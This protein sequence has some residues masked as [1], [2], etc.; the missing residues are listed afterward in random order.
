[1]TPVPGCAGHNEGANY[2]INPDSV[3]DGVPALTG[4]SQFSWK[5]GQLKLCEGY[6]KVTRNCQDGLVCYERDGFSNVPGCS[7]QGEPN[8][9]YCTNPQLSTK[10][11]NII[12][13]EGSFLRI[14]NEG[15]ITVYRA[16]G[17][18]V[19]WRSAN[20]DDVEVPLN[21]DS[22]VTNSLDSD[23][24][25]SLAKMMRY[26]GPYR[27]PDILHQFTDIDQGGLHVYETLSGSSVEI[28]STTSIAYS[29]V[30][31]HAV[32]NLSTLSFDVTVGSGIKALAICMDDGLD[33]DTRRVSTNCLILGGSK[34]NILGPNKNFVFLKEIVADDVVEAGESPN[35]DKVTAGESQDGP[36]ER[37]IRALQDD[38][39]ANYP[40]QTS[41]VPVNIKLNTIFPSTGPA[42]YFTFM[43]VA[44][45]QAAETSYSLIEN[46]Q[47][48]EDDTEFLRRKLSE[49][50]SMECNPGNLAVTG[51]PGLQNTKKSQ[52]LDFCVPSAK[53]LFE[54]SRNVGDTCVI[55]ADCRSGQCIVDKCASRVCNIDSKH[56]HI[57]FCYLTLF[58]APPL[59]TYQFF[60]MMKMGTSSNKNYIMKEIMEELMLIL[61]EEVQL[62]TKM[63]N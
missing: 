46:I 54:I 27:R 15:N 17:K 45:E 51:T 60:S 18:K 34:I 49:H 36:E 47:I 59:R 40:F 43:Q 10:S 44:D 7:G 25:I 61:K 19:V 23:V 6:C 37:R 58:H 42:K 63:D 48:A 1:M 24:S 29:L 5:F 50:T 13:N 9:N 2:C 41:T 28:H 33:F 31:S 62:L 57:T 26:A 30:A 14:G 3:Q 39:L 53:R 8:Y 20:D 21:E 11:P 32:T 4:S 52:K 12:S 56:M 38:P 16:D 35:D 55:D 22:D